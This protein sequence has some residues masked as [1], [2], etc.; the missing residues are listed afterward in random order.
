[1]KLT[2][3]GSGNAFSSDGRGHTC[4]LIEGSEGNSVLLDCGATALQG[5]QRFRPDSLST[6]DAAVITHFHG[7]HFSG[8]PFLILTMTYIQKRTRPFSIIGPAGTEKTAGGWI[9]LA[10]PG[11]TPGFPIV[12]KETEPYS[13]FN[14][15]NFEFQSLPVTHR[16]ESLGY[17]IR[18][19]QGVTAAFTGDTAFNEKMNE[20]LEGSDLGV[21][22]LSFTEK[23][24]DSPS[25]VSLEELKSLKA[26]PSKQLLLVHSDDETLERAGEWAGSADLKGRMIPGKDGMVLEYDFRKSVFLY[27]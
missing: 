21:T 14:E 6:L 1:M 23:P 12:Y 17:R 7:D 26:L 9:S 18:S 15:G 20:V 8:L 2:V 16:P 27:E 4:F 10:L 24:K 3:I 13:F 11:F 19:P 5:L 25:H 22:E